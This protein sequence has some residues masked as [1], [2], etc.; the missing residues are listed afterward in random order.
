M[1]E[2]WNDRYASNEYAY[3]IDPN[4]FL[5]E[6]L[7]FLEPGKILFPAEGEGRNAVYAATQGF[8]VFAFDPST[9]GHTK[10]LQLANKHRVNIN[11]QI[12]SY[13]SIYFEENSF[14]ILVLIFAHMPP[15]VR[16]KH[17]KKL[18]KYL[19]PV[20]TLILEGFSKEQIENNTG[21]PKDISMLFSR[22][23]LAADFEVMS[24]LVFEEKSRNL[25]EGIFH[26]GRASVIQLIGKK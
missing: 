10:A 23:E 25:N 6:Q 13:D 21:G 14:D 4:R 8:D 11:Y 19:N 18:L 5:K 16:S 2:F 15:T 1:N 7:Q 3:G 9:Q 20:G 26:Q 12:E 22:E 24:E 17:H